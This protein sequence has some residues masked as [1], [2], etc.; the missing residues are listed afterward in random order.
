MFIFAFK[1]HC[2]ITKMLRLN[3]PNYDI[4]IKECEDKKLIYDTIRHKYV[5][6][7]PEEY[8]RQNF[9]S[10]LLKDLH[11]PASL[12]GNEIELSIG[13]KRLRCDTVVYSN[14]LR[15]LMIVEYKA[16]SILLTQTVFDQISV[17]NLLLHVDYL[18]ISNGM[19]H[20]SCKMNYSDNTYRF[21]NR[22]PDYKELSA[23]VADE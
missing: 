19:E 5:T 1:N 23:S 18:V 11:Y 4:K 12:V 16:P 14:T 15:P 17:Y 2:K 6:L 20:F 21:L 22:I 10:Y 8:V 13:N 9:V 3:L 7:T